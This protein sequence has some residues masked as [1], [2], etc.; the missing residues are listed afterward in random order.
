MMQQ[1]YIK[2]K[3][4]PDLRRGENGAI[5]NVDNQKL[6]AYRK[7]RSQSVQFQQALDDINKLKTDVASIKESLEKILGALKANG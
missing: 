3:D 4:H 5:L 7:T 6:I 1:Q 2:I